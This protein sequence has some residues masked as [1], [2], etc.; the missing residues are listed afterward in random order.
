VDWFINNSTLYQTYGNYDLS[1]MSSWTSLGPQTP[2]AILD[3]QASSLLWTQQDEGLALVPSSKWG[4]TWPSVAAG[5]GIYAHV[6]EVNDGTHELVNIEYWIL[7]SWNQ[8]ICS[9]GICT[10]T[11][12]HDHAGDITVVTLV[13]SRSCDQIIQ[14]SMA[15]HGSMIDTYDLTSSPQVSFPPLKGVAPDLVTP[16]IVQSRQLS[17]LNTYYESR[18]CQWMF[19]HT[20]E[21]AF[22]ENGC[23]DSSDDGPTQNAQV[24]FVQDPDTQLYEH[25]AVF[26]EGGNHEPWPAPCGKD[27]C[28]ANHNGQGPS[29]LPTPVNYLGT[30]SDMAQPGYAYSDFVFFN[31]KWG[32]DP[33][34]PDLHNEW[35]YPVGRGVFAS[36]TSEKQLFPTITDRFAD[37]DPYQNWACVLHSFGYRGPDDDTCFGNNT[38]TWPP[39][40]G[41]CTTRLRPPTT[42]LSI[43]GPSYVNNGITYIAGTTSINLSVT[44]T[45]SGASSASSYVFVYPGGAAPPKGGTVPPFALA[46][47]PFTLSPPDGAYDIAYYS[48]DAL[49]NQEWMHSTQF[50]FDSTPPVISITQPAA[51]SY[52][53]WAT[54]VPNYSASDGGSGIATVTAK[55]DGMSTVGG[56]VLASGQSINLENLSLGTHVFTV[57]STDHVGNTSTSSVTFSL[58][59]TPVDCSV[60]ANEVLVNGQKK[61]AIT[62]TVTP[63]PPAPEFPIGRVQI[64]DASFNLQMV[65]DP[66]LTNGVASMTVKLAPTP[67][68]QWIKSI[69][70]GDTNFNGCQSQ[71]APARWVF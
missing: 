38:V 14:M 34:P 3:Y 44:R 46:S 52:P 47:G 16:V 9:S 57:T 36:S 24:F 4:E 25:I 49:K 26:H 65:P 59:T 48:I 10:V 13:Y 60:V 30:M 68:T 41:K 27:L 15:R 22:H 43:S 6:E 55:I 17:N 12:M 8:G 71:F 70:P 39:A 45:P 2:D 1:D 35:Y 29:F 53:H 33:Q 61:F 69:Y 7:Y 63:D 37:K 58:I 67:T 54:L 11:G 64:W 18:W 5:D 62:A 28:V 51:Q 32:N 50:T 56:Q 66:L 20:C 23:S 19:G 31:G 40:A 42:T 21:E